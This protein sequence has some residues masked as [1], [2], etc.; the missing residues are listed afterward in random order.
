MRPLPARGPRRLPCP[1]PFG[2]WA[3]AASR[4][5]SGACPPPSATVPD[6]GA[7][8]W[9]GCV[10]NLSPPRPL[11]EGDRPSASPPQS[12]TDQGSPRPRPAHQARRRAPGTQ[13]R[14]RP[15]RRSPPRPT[16]RPRPSCRRSSR[17]LG[18]SGGPCAA[19]GAP[20]VPVADPDHG[21]GGQHGRV[22]FRGPHSH[23]GDDPPHPTRA[24]HLGRASLPPP[25]AAHG[26]TLQARRRNP[27]SVALPCSS[28][29]G[30][31]GPRAVRVAV[32]AREERGPRA[33]TPA[34]G[35]PG[36]TRRASCRLESA[37]Q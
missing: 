28:T 13:G 8:G 32:A 35:R 27:G 9:A 21:G 26:F 25:R 2:H 10:N 3:G 24:G 29:S 4:F 15:R 19:S 14:S 22:A 6:R 34:P 23:A 18:P 30:T 11:A 17:C 7:F 37:P 20:P 12:R 5:A 1:R 31:R 33:R 36:E 16:G